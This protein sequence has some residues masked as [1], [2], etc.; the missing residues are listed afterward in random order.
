M[1]KLGQSWFL[2]VI[3]AT[4]LSAFVSKEAAGAK[5]KV[6]FV[7]YNYPPFYS[8]K[9]IEGKGYG[10]V[11]DIVIAAYNAVNFDV[12]IRY[13]PIERS[14]ANLKKGLFIAHI[15]SKEVLFQQI[16]E[17]NL[18]IVNISSYCIFFHYFK[19]HFDNKELNY[20]NIME[21]QKY[22]IGDIRGGCA[23]AI[24]ADAGIPVELTADLEQGIRKLAVRRIDLLVAV[25]L[26]ANFLVKKYMPERLYDLA[27]IKKP[28]DCGSVDLN[29]LKRHKDYNKMKALYQNGFEIIVK[30]GTYIRILEK[31]F[32]TIPESAFSKELL[33]P[34]NRFNKT[35]KKQ[36]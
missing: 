9:Y 20:G 4:I 22:S 12:I 13:Q 5:G 26:T 30:N 29:F 10:F 21:L 17:N 33:N 19:S 16:D 8:E 28:I 6:E 27:Y 36:R 25:G 15:G 14:I 34:E 3:T 7:A 31:Y 35:E 23:K 24:L 1:N 11:S 32:G 18:D 2:L